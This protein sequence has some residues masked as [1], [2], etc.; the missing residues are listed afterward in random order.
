MTTLNPMNSC[1]ITPMVGSNDYGEA[2]L[3]TTSYTEKCAIVTV[4]TIT[5][6]TTVRADSSAS[7]GYGEDFAARSKIL[8]I[9]G[10]VARMG[11]KLE[12]SGATLRI[13]S[14]HPRYT[15]W[16]QLDHYEVRGEAWD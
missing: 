14:M 2:Q 3:S 5:Q 13:I 4:E 12:V 1:V 8:L 6:H 11:D 15:I 9:P 10:T 7:R 16:G